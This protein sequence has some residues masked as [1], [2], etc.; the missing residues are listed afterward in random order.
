[1]SHTQQC[2]LCWQT[3]P[4]PINSKMAAGDHFENFKRT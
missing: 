3:V 1:V 2:L 4:Q